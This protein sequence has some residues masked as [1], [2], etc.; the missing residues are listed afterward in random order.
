M[1]APLSVNGDVPRYPDSEFRYEW[2]TGCVEP[3][4]MGTRCSPWSFWGQQ[5]G[6]P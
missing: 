1:G 6:L 4:P 2:K 3:Q 5:G